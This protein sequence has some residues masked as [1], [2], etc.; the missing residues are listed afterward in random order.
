MKM[1]VEKKAALNE[2]NIST[3][4][5]YHAEDNKFNDFDAFVEGPNF[6]QLVEMKNKVMAQVRLYNRVIRSFPKPN[7]TITNY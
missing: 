3:L 4:D 5:E 6:A 2:T 1:A 7:L